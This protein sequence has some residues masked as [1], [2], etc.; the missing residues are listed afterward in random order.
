MTQIALEHSQKTDYG[1]RREILS[2]METLAQSVGQG[3]ASQGPFTGVFQNRIMP[4][5]NAIWSPGK[6]RH[7]LGPMFRT[8]FSFAL[9]SA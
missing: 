9:T 1:L 6:H 7:I 2:P 3:A 4:S 8:N 5:A